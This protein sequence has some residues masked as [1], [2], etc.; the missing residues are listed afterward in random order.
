MQTASANND[1]DIVFKI[2]VLKKK[3]PK[4][5]P[6]DKFNGDITL[7]EEKVIHQLCEIIEKYS[8]VIDG[9]DISKPD[10]KGKRT[11]V[12]RLR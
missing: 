7:K 10:E 11:I 12:F 5:I 3:S 9:F 4:A 1:I 6:Y 8:E 2:P